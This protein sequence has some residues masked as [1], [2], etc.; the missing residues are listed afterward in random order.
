[1][2]TAERVY[3]VYRKMKK[4][5]L[6]SIAALLMATSGAAAVELPACDDFGVQKT[7][8]RVSGSSAVRTA[9]DLNSDKTDKRWC[10]AAVWHAGGWQ[11]TYTVEFIN[12][13]QGRYWVENPIPPYVRVRT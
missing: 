10:S 1:L 4:L 6:T 9:R 11:L 5:L 13:D 8:M 2:G 7:L 3:R 12:A